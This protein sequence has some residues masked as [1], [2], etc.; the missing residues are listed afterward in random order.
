MTTVLI[1]VNEVGDDIGETTFRGEP[2]M[3]T[4][5]IADDDAE[6]VGELFGVTS[7]KVAP[8]RCSRL[9][10]QLGVDAEMS[11]KSDCK[12]VSHSPFLLTDNASMR[13]VFDGRARLNSV[14]EILRHRLAGTD[15][16]FAGFRFGDL[17]GVIEND[18][19]DLNTPRLLVFGGPDDCVRPAMVMRDLDDPDEVLAE[20]ELEVVDVS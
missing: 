9:L 2:L 13:V 19:G 3:T 12:D 10:V 6:F 11:W 14:S 5:G 15:W 16:S 7:E 8:L 4:T 1:W 18:R 17:E 20:V